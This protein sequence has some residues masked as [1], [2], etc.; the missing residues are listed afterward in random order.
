MFTKKQSHF[1]V[2]KLASR[3]RLGNLSLFFTPSLEFE[4]LRSKVV[5]VVEF[6]CDCEVWYKCKNVFFQYQTD[7][8]SA[9]GHF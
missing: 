3:R 8:F 1:A 2:D 6:G 5:S 4:E 9:I 7:K